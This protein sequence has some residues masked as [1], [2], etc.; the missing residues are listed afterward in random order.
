ML[1]ALLAAALLFACR[2]VSSGKQPPR[3]RGGVLDLSS[4]DFQRDGPVPLNG[5]WL[6]HW[7][8]LVQPPITTPGV[9]VRLPAVWNQ[10]R[11]RGQS[12]GATGF[13]TL[14]MR[15]EL[16]PG[17]DH[18]AVRVPEIGSAY[19]LYANQRLVTQA[20]Q[21]GRTAQEERGEWRTGYGRLEGGTSIELLLHTSNFH[22]RAGGAWR[23]L[24]LGT[25]AQIEAIRRR[26]VAVELFMIGAFFI[27]GLNH[28][29]IFAGRRKFRATLYFG[30]L[31]LLVVLQILFSGER[32]LALA[33][34]GMPYRFMHTIQFAT[35]FGAI[36]IFALFESH[37]FPEEFHR[38]ALRAIL[39]GSLIFLGLSVVLPTLWLTQLH[40]LYKSFAFGAELYLIFVVILA[41]R[42]RRPGG[43]FFLVGLLVLVPVTVMN[44]FLQRAGGLGN[45]QLVSF[46]FLFFVML[47]SIMLSKRFTK[48]LELAEQKERAELAAMQSQLQ[49]SEARL[50]LE[51]AQ[52]DRLKRIIQPHYLLNSLTALLQWVKKDPDRAQDLVR[53]LSS[54]FHRVYLAGQKERVAILDEIDLCRVHA[55]IMGSRYERSIAFETAG[56]NEELKVPP[57]IFHTLIENAFFH[58]S[59]TTIRI[60]QTHPGRF[61]I[62]TSGPFRAEQ[63]GLGIGLDYVRARLRATYGEA[64][65]LESRPEG[66]SWLTEIEI[67]TEHSIR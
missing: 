33:F 15:V 42:R 5:E 24:L 53:D 66:E 12:L 9:P 18:L 62:R 43:R 39:A 2:P 49:Y 34:P 8:R 44:I 21:V 4:W 13:G 30:I 51:R 46:A 54:E 6:L 10:Y 56:I 64:W 67:N 38:L 45:P 59:V 31:C 61:V 35:I 23:P 25:R 29:T 36:P 65:Q 28:L 57:L 47:Q 41:V 48:A 32:L 20:G 37:V 60:E 63:R 58:Q 55:A 17:S 3:V 14:R 40:V 27:I 22:Y 50:S 1:I 26:A 7:K 16:P 11:I 19:R 52:S